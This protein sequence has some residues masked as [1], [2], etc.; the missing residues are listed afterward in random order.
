[1]PDAA[2]AKDASAETRHLTLAVGGMTC[3]SCVSRVEK[4]LL[5]VPGVEKAAVNLAT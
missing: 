4:A 5:A 1:M 3:A 2:A